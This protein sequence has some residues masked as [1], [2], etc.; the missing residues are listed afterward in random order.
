MCKPECRVSTS[1]DSGWLDPACT[2]A[3]LDG[4]A[5][6]FSPCDDAHCPATCKAN[7]EASAPAPVCGEY[8]ANGDPAA[9]PPSHCYGPDPCSQA[10]PT[11]YYDNQI[12]CQRHP[13]QGCVWLPDNSPYV[14]IDQR[15]LPFNNRSAC[16]QCPENCRI[17]SY[18][19]DC[20]F[21]NNINNQYA[22]CSATACPSACRAPALN[23]DGATCKD[24]A[25]PTEACNN[26]PA[27][28]RR[29][30]GSRPA[31][32]PLECN[33]VG[34]TPQGNCIASCL[35]SDAPQRLCQRCLDCPLDCTYYP[36]VRTDCSSVC[37]DEALAGP[38][39]IAPDDFIKKLPGASGASDVK[40]VGTL[41]VPAL[42]LPLFCIVIVIAFI[43]VFSPILGGDIEIPGLGKII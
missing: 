29:S 26:C 34:G 37:S 27:L 2:K 11:G 17:D 39:S 12:V 10:Q 16:Q 20:G 18:Y 13:E 21:A 8:L 28:C 19:G 38:V 3:T 33:D 5:T 14:P 6:H 40:G 9:S 42:V 30:D 15:A 7:L 32:C 4:G 24:Y 25:A 23:I 31:D 43:R 35:L 1:N 36:A 22:D 41:M